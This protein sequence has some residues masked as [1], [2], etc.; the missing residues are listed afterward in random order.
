MCRVIY[1]VK[2]SLFY[3]RHGDLSV[4]KM[5]ST[6]S[7]SSLTFPLFELS[8]VAAATHVVLEPGREGVMYLFK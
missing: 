4:A 3:T 8:I 7:V 5:T 1:M 2:L 6:S